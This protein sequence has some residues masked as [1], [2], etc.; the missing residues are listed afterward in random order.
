M[1]NYYLKPLNLKTKYIT[2]SRIV[3]C[4]HKFE[5]YVNFKI[6]FHYFRNALFSQQV[7]IENFT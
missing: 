5:P 2:N 1:N 3:G 4:S 7:S 6:I